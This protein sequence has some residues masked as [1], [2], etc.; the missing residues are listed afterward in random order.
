MVGYAPK[1][2]RKRARYRAHRSLQLLNIAPVRFAED[3][4]ECLVKGHPDGL[5]WKK[6]FDLI[7]VNTQMVDRSILKRMREL[8]H[9]AKV[10][11]LL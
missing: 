6:Q 3:V 10:S 7:M 2:V 9:A 1:E 11:L 8:Q 5:N 4:H